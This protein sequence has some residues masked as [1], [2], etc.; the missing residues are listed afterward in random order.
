MTRRKETSTNSVNRTNLVSDCDL[1][2]ALYL[3]GGRWKLLIIGRLVAGRL[4]FTELKEQM[5]GVT[6]RMLTLQLRELERDGLIARTL[7]AAVPPRVD[8]ELTPLGSKLVPVCLQL[9]EWG[10]MHK[11]ELGL[12]KPNATV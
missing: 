5:P 11:Q 1:M 10:T 9:Q 7:Y 3:I 6:D 8:Y 12:L 2:H 4:R